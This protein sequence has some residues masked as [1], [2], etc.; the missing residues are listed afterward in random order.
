MFAK[1]T[2]QE[3]L[4]KDQGGRKSEQQGGGTEKREDPRSMPGGKGGMR[5]TARGSQARAGQTG[6]TRIHLNL[7]AWPGSLKPQ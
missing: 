5:R 4:K 7:P 2:Q 3:Q 6:L 1:N